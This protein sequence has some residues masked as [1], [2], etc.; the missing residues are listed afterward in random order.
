[1]NDYSFVNFKDFFEFNLRKYSRDSDGTKLFT[2]QEFSKKLGYNSPSLL[3]MIASGKRLP[4]NEILEV[5]FDEWKIDHNLREIIRIRLE[6][7][8]K[9]K[10]NKP[11]L[12]LVEKLS[13]LDKKSKFKPIDLDTFNSIKEWHNIVLQLMVSTPDFKE[14]YSLMSQQLRRKVT[15]AQVRRGIE[16]LVKVGLLKRNSKTGN[17]ESRTADDS[18]ET[19]HDIPSEA[20]REHH[21]GMI[22]RALESIDE[23]SVDE[24]H[25]NSLTIKFDQNK[26]VEAKMAIL[27]F[28][29]EFNQKFHDDDSNDIYQLNIQ[30]FG[31][32]NI[33]QK[34]VSK[35]LIQ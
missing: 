21:R 12:S 5:L 23:Q 20:I 17:L 18:C 10:R 33:A 19:T 22:S 26:K 4:S 25:L 29:K 6:I 30:F 31:H 32:T 11:T 14:D 2:L 8:K 24:R 28:V 16:T 35:D 7:E 1:M 27:N 34:S 13:R 9:I 15:P 3:S